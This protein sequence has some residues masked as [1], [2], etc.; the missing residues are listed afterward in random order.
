MSNTGELVHLVVG[1]FGNISFV[2]NNLVNVAVFGVV[3][4]EEVFD[5]VNALSCLSLLFLAGE[6]VE[7]VVGVVGVFAVTEGYPAEVAVYIILV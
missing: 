3:V 4:V 7:E 1:E 6:A 2:Y 5:F